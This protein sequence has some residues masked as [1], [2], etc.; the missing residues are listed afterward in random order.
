MKRKGRY[1][2]GAMAVA[3]V[4]ASI[5]PVS[6]QP[7]YEPSGNIARFSDVLSVPMAGAAAAPMRIEV[8][9]WNLVGTAKAFQLPAQG[10]YVAQLRSG[11]VFTNIAGKSEKR[12]AGDFW[13]VG[14]G[15]PMTVTF[16]PHGEAA[17]LQTIAVNPNH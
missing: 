15:V 5:G 2:L 11:N 1:A 10:F 9:E 7:L 17:Q 13:T 6:G 4:L 16:A 12:R 3:V 8:R 14:A